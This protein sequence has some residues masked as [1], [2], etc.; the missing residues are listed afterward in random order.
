MI[1][2]S[3]YVYSPMA[4]PLLSILHVQRNSHAGLYGDCSRRFIETSA[5]LYRGWRALGYPFLGYINYQR[6]HAIEY[7]ITLRTA[8]LIF[9]K[10]V[11]CL[12][13]SGI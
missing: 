6:M 1:Y 8:D 4:I 3:K 13:N 7:S 9:I 10:K 11:I 12:K 5:L 2:S